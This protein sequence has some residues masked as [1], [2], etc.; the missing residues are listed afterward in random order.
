MEKRIK[1]DK[2]VFENGLSYVK[3]KT[4]L[5]E[6]VDSQQSTGPNQS[7]AFI[8]YTKLSER[9]MHRWDKTLHLTD[10]LKHQIETVDYQINI[11]AITE[12]WCGDAA[13]NL[14]IFQKIA[15]LNSNIQLRI[16]LRD[17]HED[18]IDAYLTNGGRSIPKVIAFDEEEIELFNWGPRPEPA[19]KLY[20]DGKSAGKPYDEL[21]A[22]L[23]TFY[24]NDKAI[25]IQKELSYL[26]NLIQQKSL[27][28]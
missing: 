3:Y 6:L 15:E 19:Q 10:D 25:T 9:R 26:F 23:Q 8:N 16:I 7:E 22:E 2:L 1:F 18:V 12:S 17:E 21:S 5:K 13:H 28:N 14:P 4:L 27:A 24:N 20:L 11:L